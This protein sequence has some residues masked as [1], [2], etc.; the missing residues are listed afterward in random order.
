MAEPV[1]G[2]ARHPGEIALTEGTADEWLGDRYRNLCVGFA[3]KT[4]N[5]G[6]IEP[7]P[8]LRHVKPAVAGKP[9][10]HAI[11]ESEDRS[12]AAGRDIVHVPFLA[13]RTV[14]ARGA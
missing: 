3:G 13:G 9:G 8:H 6:G 2:L 14:V 7:R 11:D 5:R 1:I 12:L 10:K 4:R